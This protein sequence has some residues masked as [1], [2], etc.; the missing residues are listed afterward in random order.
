MAKYFPKLTIYMNES[1]SGIAVRAALEN[2]LSD[3]QANARRW[4]ALGLFAERAGF[5]L[6]DGNNLI[7]SQAVKLIP[8]TVEPDTPVSK[9]ATTSPAATPEPVKMSDPAEVV[10]SST[11][12]DPPAPASSIPTQ[13]RNNLIKL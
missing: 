1:K 12:I 7:P 8:S 2:S 3:A 10:L 6:D 9:P 13:L 4:L 11:Q 5:R